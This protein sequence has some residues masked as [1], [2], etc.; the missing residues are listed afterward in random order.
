[1]VLNRPTAKVG[2][3]TWETQA[4]GLQGEGAGGDEAGGTF[5][6]RTGGWRA[7]PQGRTRVKGTKSSR[8]HGAG[9]SFFREGT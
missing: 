2:L 9:G 8:M 6:N 7:R 5:S 4:P 3:P 1:M